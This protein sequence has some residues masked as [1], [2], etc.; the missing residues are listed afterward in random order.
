MLCVYAA[1]E[2]IH[3][4]LFH[5]ARYHP[6]CCLL[7]DVIHVTRKL[8]CTQEFIDRYQTAGNEE[9]RFHLQLHISEKHGNVAEY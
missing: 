5:I 8:E 1:I 6:R 2:R 7:V 3:D 9:V 4:R